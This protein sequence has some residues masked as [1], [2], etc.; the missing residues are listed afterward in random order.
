MATS[1]YATRMVNNG[2]PP[3]EDHINEYNYPVDSGYHIKIGIKKPGGSISKYVRT[4]AAEVGKET[5][6][7][8]NLEQLETKDR[9]EIS[10][11]GLNET[12]E[13]IKAGGIVVAK[14]T[15]IFKA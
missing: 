15:T 4:R 1:L 7:Y 12:I 8:V 3:T 11:L 2:T 13:E 14:I 6:I 9:K 5:C 10:D